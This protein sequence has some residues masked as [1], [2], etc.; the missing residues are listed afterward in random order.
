MDGRVT[1]G[2]KKPLRFYFFFEDSYAR[3]KVKV[4]SV[5]F[6][7]QKLLSTKHPLSSILHLPIQLCN[8]QLTA[9]VLVHMLEWY[10]WKTG[11]HNS[12]LCSKVYLTIKVI[13]DEFMCS[14]NKRFLD[15]LCAGHYSGCEG[16][17]SDHDWQKSSL[18]WSLYFIRIVKWV[19]LAHQ[20]V[21]SATE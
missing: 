11:I 5:A 13:T 9:D 1:W 20:W 18:S 6:T 17:V 19:N 2:I 7:G 16:S 12:S 21:V 10:P 15:L 4:L 8:L 3:T 14:F